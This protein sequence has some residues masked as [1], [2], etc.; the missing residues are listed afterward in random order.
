MNADALLRLLDAARRDESDA[1]GRLLDAHRNYL[2]LLARIQVGR[3]LQGKVDPA[4]L[5]Q[6]TFLDAHRQFSQFR[7]DTVKSVAAWLRRILAGQIAHLVR[8][9]FSAEA[10]D[11]RLEQSIEHELD[12]SSEWLAKG[13]S[14][15]GSSPS[16]AAARREE[17]IRLGDALE[18][19]PPDYRD[20]ILLRQIEGLQF[21]EVARRLGRTEDSVQKL[22]VRGLDSLRKILDAAG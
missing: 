8:R 19:L 4:D 1:L 6:D 7:G 15:P 17:L 13:M 22:W 2:T 20:V 9:Y 11:V 14:S 21:A 16:E 5:V 12:S 3:R 18:Q 10:R